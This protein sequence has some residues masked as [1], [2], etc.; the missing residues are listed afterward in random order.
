MIAVKQEKGIA[1]GDQIPDQ[2]TQEGNRE[3][4]QKPISNPK[5]EIA[6]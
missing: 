3:I 5:S 6:N 4:G 1:E 2:S